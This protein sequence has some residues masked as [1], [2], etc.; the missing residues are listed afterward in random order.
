[1]K[2]E[3]RPLIPFLAAG[4]VKDA[5]QVAQAE[6]S[7]LQAELSAQLAARRSTASLDEPNHPVCSCETTLRVNP[8]VLALSEK[9]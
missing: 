7:G 8:Q 4:I 9:S 1:M 2:R 3:D 5:Q 6:V